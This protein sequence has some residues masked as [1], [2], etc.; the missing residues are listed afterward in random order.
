MINRQNE[1]LIHAMVFFIKKTKHCYKLK[2]FKLLYFLDFNH[3]KET[4]R[5]VT[6]LEYFAW[7]MG[8]VPKILYDKINSQMEE[9]KIFFKFIPESFIDPD[10]TKDK[11]IRFIPKI[12]FDKNLFSKRELHIMEKLIYLYKDVKSKDMTEISHDRKG[13][14]YKVFKQENKPQKTIPYEYILD[15]SSQSISME[16]AKEITQENKEMENTFGS[17]SSV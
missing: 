3:F 5:S 16:E 12:E 4:G 1:K 10:F 7:P 9:L 15:N 17:T 11:V 2:L 6:G 14:W 13:P 8:P